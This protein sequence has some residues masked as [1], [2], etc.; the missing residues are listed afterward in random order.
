MASDRQKPSAPVLAQ[1]GEYYRGLC[2]VTSR[3]D[4]EFHHLDDNKTRSTFANLIPLLGYYNSPVLRDAAKNARKG[5][6]VI[7]PAGL[8]PETLLRTARIK[9]ASWDISAAYGCSRLAYFIAKNYKGYELNDIITMSCAALYY[10]RNSFNYKLIWDVLTRDLEPAIDGAALGSVRRA[11][12]AQ[13]LAGILSE[14]GK[15][16]LASQL[17]GLVP[18]LLGSNTSAIGGERHAAFLRRSANIVISEHGMTDEAEGLLEDALSV[19]LAS[20]NMQSGIVNSRGWSLLAERKYAAALD[21]VS[22]LYYA[23]SK[24][25]FKTGR[26]PK[27]PTATDASAWNAA[28]L[29]HNYG[30]SAMRVG[31]KY[32]RKGLI[33]LKNAAI[34]YARSHLRPFAV[35]ENFWANE[36]GLHREL[37]LSGVKIPAIVSLPGVITDKIISLGRRLA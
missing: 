23:H 32:E 34:I 35:R 11:E 24:H 12:I 31:G 1:L 9:F 27:T 20:Q 4:I 33:A 10:A 29:F 8:D 16:A 3:P 25:I 28:E 18:K 14:H 19:N 26:D 15:Y 36:R 5:T 22:P 17:L 6:H 2:V 37:A 21:V 30:I 13:E 7:L